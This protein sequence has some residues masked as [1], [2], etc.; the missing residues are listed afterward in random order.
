MK[1][2]K[3][4][5]AMLLSAAMTLSMTVVP[6]FA[7]GTVTLTKPEEAVVA[8]QE[9]EITY[10][11][12]G[13][14]DNVAV[15]S[16]GLDYDTTAFEFVSASSE[17]GTPVVND[18]MLSVA[19]AA[20]TKAN[21]Q[22][23]RFVYKVKTDAYGN[24]YTFT[25]KSGLEVTDAAENSIVDSTAF[26]AATVTVSAP[27]KLDTP[28]VTVSGKK[29]SWDPVTNAK[30]YEVVIEKDGKQIYTTKTTATELDFSSK[31]TETGTYKATVKALDN[32]YLWKESDAGSNQDE[33][34]VNSTVT[35]TDKSYVQGSKGFDVTMTLNGNTFTGIDGLAKDTDYSVNGNVVTIFDSALTTSKTLTFNFSKGA[36]AT[37]TV[38]VTPAADAINFILAEREKSSYTAD[39]TTANDGT[40][41]G[42]IVV[43]AGSATAPLTDFT[44]VSFKVAN[45]AATGYSAIDYE[46]VPADG[47]NLL[48]HE[49]T[50]VYEINVK[51]GTDGKSSVSENP[52]QGGIVIGYLKYPGGYGKGKISASDVRITTKATDGLYKEF[53]AAQAWD[54]TYDVKEKTQKLTI[55][56]DF[57]LPT[58]TNN[59]ANYEK[60]GLN[61]YSARLGNTAIELGNDVTALSQD[62]IKA[63][64]IGVESFTKADNKY[65]VVIAN[66]PAFDTYTVSI[67]GDGY[68]TAK[69]S[70]NLNEDKTVMFW[71][72]AKDSDAVYVKTAAGATEKMTSK[73]FLAG[74]IIMDGKI[75]LYDLSAVSSYFGKG[76]GS[77]LDID[78]NGLMNKDAEANAQYIQYDLNRDGKID[79]IDI[80]M[81][82]AGW[83]K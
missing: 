69:T 47:F 66:L 59:A 37:V 45:D 18:S 57:N 55:D 33:Y 31:V 26:D 82:L 35:P 62:D 63:G 50:G 15:V 44:A 2:T 5:L 30:D 36:S 42:A 6:A 58:E 32:G 73:N 34:V 78:A 12:E 60:M 27:A 13:N 25:I 75:D 54:F 11:L 39:D 28:N 41:D 52:A 23:A 81:V 49:D 61:V 80:T 71:N 8:G 79:I 9:F 4:V 29:A 51:P 16:I 19:L 68:R 65:T 10:N 67:N 64:K 83:A 43:A 24:D 38:T 70:L 1:S 40:E 21:G 46:I 17:F 56:V 77:N 53:N 74:D 76:T 14:T 3:K 7:A 22:L 48:Y 72:N 20:G